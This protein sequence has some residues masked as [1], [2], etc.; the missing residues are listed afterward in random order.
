MGIII[1]GMMPNISY[2]MDECEKAY[3]INNICLVSNVLS[4]R[5]PYTHCNTATRIIFFF[6]E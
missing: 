1:S 5:L 3:T 2:S 4:Q 6:G